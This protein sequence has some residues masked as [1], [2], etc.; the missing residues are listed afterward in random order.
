[1]TAFF[2]VG[3]YIFDLFKPSVEKSNDSSYKTCYSKVSKPFKK[4]FDLVRSD[5]M[6]YIYTTGNPYCNSAR[7][8]EYLSNNSAAFEDNQSSSRVYRLSAH[9]FIGG[10]ASLICLYLKGAI[11]PTAVLIIF[12]SSFF[13]STFFISLHADAA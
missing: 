3:D 10:V 12:F 2:T 6:S 7:Y 1:M 8:C 4:L 11:V 13:I 9:M 5:A